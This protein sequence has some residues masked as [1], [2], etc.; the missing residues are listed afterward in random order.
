MVKRLVMLW[1]QMVDVLLDVSV[2]GR[3]MVHSSCTGGSCPHQ[4]SGFL[5]RGNDAVGWRKPWGAVHGH[6]GAG[7]DEQV[8]TDGTR[9]GDLALTHGRGPCAVSPGLTELINLMHDGTQVGMAT[10][11]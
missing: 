5:L 3:Q 2:V 10:L 9:V 6:P 8:S 4:G 11:L 7:A 1:V